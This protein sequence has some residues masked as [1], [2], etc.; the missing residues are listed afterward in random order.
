MNEKNL[1]DGKKP[2]F[3]NKEHMNYVKI[4][5]ALVKISTR[6]PRKYHERL[7]EIAKGQVKKIGRVEYYAQVLMD[8]VDNVDKTPGE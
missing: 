5:Q 4:N 1:I 3:G 6:I 8:H 2:E 7:G